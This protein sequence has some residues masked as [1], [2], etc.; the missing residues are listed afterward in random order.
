MQK[1]LLTKYSH[2]APIP[3]DG[4]AKAPD[5]PTVEFAH[6]VLTQARRDAVN[7]LIGP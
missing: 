1:L 4:V 6:P 7:S 3:A 2:N 5:R